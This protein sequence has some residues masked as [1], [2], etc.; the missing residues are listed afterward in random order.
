MIPP[1]SLLP[2]PCP[3]RLGVVIT[4]IEQ[5]VGPS[6]MLDAEVH[7]A[8]GWDVWTAAGATR[9]LVMRAPAS[10]AVRPVPEASTSLD[11]AAATRPAGW[12]WGIALREQ[13]LGWCLDPAAPMR[14]TE[15]RDARPA[16][17]L[18]R[19]CLHAQR[20]VAITP[21]LQPAEVMGCACGWS[22]PADALRS[23][24]CPDCDRGIAGSGAAARGA[25][26]AGSGAA[27]QGAN[28]SALEHAH[29]AG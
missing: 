19:A 13:A 18:L 22:G 7:A 2:A 28:P 8:L 16:M 12:Y 1:T 11:A 5:G 20:L 27:A 4:A 26:S 23:G 14:F 3:T 25:A 6:R 17:A 24:R 15:C 9:R 10:T 29:A 21:A